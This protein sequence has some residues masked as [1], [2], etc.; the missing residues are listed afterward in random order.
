MSEAKLDETNDS[1]KS[2]EE[3]AFMDHVAQCKECRDAL[4]WTKFCSEGK[5]RLLSAT[6]G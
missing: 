5:S 6:R 3:S 4:H 2:P 1:G